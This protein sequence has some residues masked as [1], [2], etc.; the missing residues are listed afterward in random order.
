MATAKIAALAMPNATRW[1]DAK[2][3]KLLSL[4]SFT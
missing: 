2:L 3:P 4:A 1:A